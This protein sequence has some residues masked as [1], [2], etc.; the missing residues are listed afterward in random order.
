MYRQG[1]KGL[2]R[3]TNSLNIRA[4]GPEDSAPELGAFPATTLP[5]PLPLPHHLFPSPPLAPCPSAVATEP[6]RFFS[7]GIIQGNQWGASFRFVLLFSTQSRAHQHPLFSRGTM[8]TPIE[9]DLQGCGLTTGPQLP[10]AIHQTQ[11]PIKSLTHQPQW[12]TQG[13]FER[14]SGGSGWGRS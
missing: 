2:A 3:V 7:S 9:N 11:A 13:R 6:G 1:S 5:L 12:P 8:R 14:G 4:A 10:R